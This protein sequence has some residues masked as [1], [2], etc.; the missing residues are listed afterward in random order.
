MGW[1]YSNTKFQDAG[2]IADS[3]ESDLSD[4][5]LML[6]VEDQ[7]TIRHRSRGPCRVIT[8]YVTGPSAFLGYQVCGQSQAGESLR[9]LQVPTSEGIN[10][11]R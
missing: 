6:V 1:I 5:T 7:T 3:A 2:F 9:A 4:D 8:R 10:C 11:C